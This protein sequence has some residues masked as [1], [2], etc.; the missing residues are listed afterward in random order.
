[1]VITNNPSLLETIITNMSHGNHLFIQ[2]MKILLDIDTPNNTPLTAFFLCH[3]NPSLF[4][5]LYQF[6]KTDTEFLT[7]LLKQIHIKTKLEDSLLELLAER[8]PNILDEI[9]DA[10][11]AKNLLSPWLEILDTS[12]AVN[13]NG[14][15]LLAYF[16]RPEQLDN[17]L[18]SLYN[19][20]ETRIKLAFIN[21]NSDFETQKIVIDI[22]P[23]KLVK[24]PDNCQEKQECNHSKMQFFNKMAVTT[25]AN[26]VDQKTTLDTSSQNTIQKN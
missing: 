12:F 16:H 25:K 21:N 17:L 18:L 1:M 9:I 4:L 13:V 22:L 8:Y 3:E 19:T 26:A 5:K 14:L 7:W 11:I 15:D 24:Q 10:S 6:I 20:D 2:V 23:V